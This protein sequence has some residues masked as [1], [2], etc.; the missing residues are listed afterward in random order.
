[1]WKQVLTGAAARALM[2]VGAVIVVALGLAAC[3]GGSSSSSSASADSSESNSSGTNEGAG[4]EASGETESAEGKTVYFL[5]CGPETPYCAVQNREM[6]KGLEEHGVNAVIQNDGPYD[7]TIQTKQLNNAIAQKPALIAGVFT[8]QQ[9]LRPALMKAQ[10]ENIP[11][12]AFNT[13][14]AEGF[15][16]LFAGHVGQDDF[17]EGLIGGELM[18][19]GLQEAGHKEGRVII[20]SGAQGDQAAEARNAGFEKAMEAAPEFEITTAWSNWLPT[21]A[22]SETQQLL[23]KYNDIVGFFGANSSMAASSIKAAEQAGAEIGGKGGIVYTGGNCDPSAQEY[24]VN[25][26]MKGDNAQ[27]PYT[28]VETEVGVI[29]KYLETG[30]LPANT[31]V[32]EPVVTKENVAKYEKVC[33]F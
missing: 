6:Q 24:I 23:A 14:I 32:P 4:E 29:V 31:R 1:M 27:S 5:G 30:E 8:T 21:Q 16:D 20:L 22:A 3:G 25:G 17:N 2:V 33:T 10:Q 28:D 15:E 13:P 18:V 7:V 26:T 9:P 12:V 19:E 11:I